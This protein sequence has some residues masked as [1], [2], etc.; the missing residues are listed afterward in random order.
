M[1]ETTETGGSSRRSILLSF[2]GGAAA[3]VG[4]TAMP[5]LASADEAAVNE[6]ITGMV[7]DIP[8][9]GSISLDLPEIA[10]NGNTVPMS[11]E[12]DAP[13]GED[14]Y[15]KKVM[16]LADGNPEPNVAVFHF[17]PLSGKAAASTRMRL[18]GTQNVVAVAEMSDGSAV[19]GKKEVKVTI[20]GCGG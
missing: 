12:V 20:G 11:F 18:A 6:A 10:E 19:M 5:G 1:F 16:V 4:L 3:V 9:E 13:M 14:L 2:G 8:P 15:V 17:S 7:G